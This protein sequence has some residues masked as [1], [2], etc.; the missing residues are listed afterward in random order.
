[1]TTRSPFVE[2]RRVA[3]FEDRKCATRR[4]STSS[5]QAVM[6]SGASGQDLGRALLAASLPFARSNGIDDAVIE[7]EEGNAAGRLASEFSAWPMAH[8]PAERRARQRY[9][10]PTA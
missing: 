3:H 5:D 6:S 4:I 8:L 10:L 7:L 1:M 9:L 2:M